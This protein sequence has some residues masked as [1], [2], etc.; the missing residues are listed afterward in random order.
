MKVVVTPPAFYKSES[1]KSKLSSL[2]PN[3]VYN[4]NANYLSGEELVVFLKDADAAIIGRDPVTQD[5]LN[6]L[7]QLK[8][9]SKYGVGFDNLDL[10]AIKKRG[11]ELAVTTGINKRSVAELTLSFMVGLCHNIFISAERMKRGEWIRD[12]GQDLSGKTIGIIGCGNVGKEVIKL[13]KPFGCKILINDIEDRSEFCREQSAIESSFELLIKESDIVSLHVPLTNLTRDMIN[14]NVLKDM[15]ANAFLVNTSRGP[16][17]NSSHLHRALVSKQILGAAL[18]VFCS[19]PPDD[20]EFLQ[21][22]QLMVTPHIG[23]NSREAVEAM[24]QAAIDNLL[25]YFNK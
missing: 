13:L 20:I 17:V 1:L 25:K 24:G 23:G 2:F 6:A 5:T 7:P 15:K 16:V 12:G 4:Q 18:D 9:I 11:V 19:E 10:N 8:M 21:L 3:T 22:S 14:K